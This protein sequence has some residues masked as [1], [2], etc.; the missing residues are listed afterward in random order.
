MK[1]RPFSKKKR[2]GNKV[3]YRYVYGH[4][5]VIS[6]DESKELDERLKAVEE[7]ID[8]FKPEQPHDHQK[9]TDENRARIAL[10]FVK[11]FARLIFFALIAV[12]LY[13]WLALK[14]P[15]PIEI[16]K[17]LAQVAGILGTPLGFIVGYYFEK[18]DKSN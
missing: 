6:Y 8:S 4:N 15:Q 5:S 10:Y 18:G 9:H 14:N 7:N 2:G 3:E 16:D 12:P 1:W 17:T 11:A 13:N